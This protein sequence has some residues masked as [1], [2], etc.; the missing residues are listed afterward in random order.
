MLYADSIFLHDNAL[1]H[2]SYLVKRWLE[3]MGIE[4]MEWPVYSLDLN[5]IENLWFLLKEKIYK[6]YPELL[7]L[8]G[9]NAILTL[10]RQPRMRGITLGI[11]FSTVCQIPWFTVSAQS[12]TQLKCYTKY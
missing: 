4:V 11:A 6:R 3:E 2:K 8:H 9:K 12:W 1:I 10:I 7:D 5:L